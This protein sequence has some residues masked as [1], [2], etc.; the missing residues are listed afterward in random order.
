M[1][2]TPLHV[3]A[4]A[5]SLAAC[6]MLLASGADPLRENEDG[7]RPI[8]VATDPAVVAAL[9]ASLPEDVAEKWRKE[10]EE[11]GGEA[12]LAAAAATPAWDANADETRAVAVDKPPSWRAAAAVFL[13]LAACLCLARWGRPTVAAG[14]FGRL[15]STSS[16][17]R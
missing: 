13:G 10:E 5:G 4:D 14:M 12:V 6:T 2:C 7:D 3:A 15:W 9:L 1:D 17:L 16:S 8:D 11:A